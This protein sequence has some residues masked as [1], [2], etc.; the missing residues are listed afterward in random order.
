VLKNAIL[1]N[2]FGTNGDGK[3]FLEAIAMCLGAG[4]SDNITSAIRSLNE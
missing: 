3:A 4:K 1:E 2:A